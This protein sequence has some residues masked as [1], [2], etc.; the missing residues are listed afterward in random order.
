[1][2]APQYATDVN[3]AARQR[4]WTQSP[5][6]RELDPFGWMAS[7]VVGTRVVEIGCG[8]GRYLERIDGAIGLDLSMG[9]LASAAERAR[10][11]LLCADAQALPF[12]DASF[13][14]VLAPMMLYHVPDRARAAHEMRRV[15]RPGGVAIA[16]TNSGT[17]QHELR[18][19]VE[20]VV[21]N[22]WRWRRPSDDDFSMEN[23][24]EQLA[25]A[26]DIVERHD[27]EP[28]ISRVVAAELVTGYV[29]SVADPYEAETG[30]VWSDVAAECGRRVAAIIAERG[31]FDITLR[32][33]AFICR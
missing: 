8:N 4:L 7:Q 23:G 17:T 1:M 29:A 15:L 14:T 27:Y 16:A 3:L 2:P 25:V 21:G 32:G 28:T 30:L 22:G 20:D 11:P 5:R 6:D 33:G 19:L 18:S 26:F 12:A 9:M 13:D 31:S 10:G 24:G